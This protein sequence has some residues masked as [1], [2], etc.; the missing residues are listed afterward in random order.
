MRLS[1]TVVGAGVA[2]A[3]ALAFA[4]KSSSNPCPGTQALSLAGNYSL[5]S[6]TLGAT[7]IPVPPASGTLKFGSSSSSGGGKYNFTVSYPNPSPPPTT[8]TVVD[9]GTYVLTGSS[10]IS[11]TSLT[12]QPSFSGDYTLSAAFPSSGSTFSVKGTAA[13]QSVGS[14]WTKQ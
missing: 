8:T 12:G 11:E 9:S 7:T 14:V 5:A 10:C 1:V 6:Y 2:F 13:G 3:S 4:C